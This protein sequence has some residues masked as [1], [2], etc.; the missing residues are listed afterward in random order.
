M[1]EKILKPGL[2]ASFKKRPP[3]PIYSTNQELDYLLTTCQVTEVVIASASEMIDPLL[4]DG[5][6]TVG[7]YI[8]LSHDEPTCAQ[9]GGP[10]SVTLT[11]NTIKGN[12]V[13]L[14]FIC[15]DNIGIICRGKH[16]RAVVDKL[17]LR[18]A[19]YKRAEK[20]Q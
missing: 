15:K 9:G 10:V 13:I 17:K 2:T 1:L 3:Q 6:L 20:S 4:S 12:K 16:E 5:Y 14:D 7:R 8:E 11:V 18:E 19:T